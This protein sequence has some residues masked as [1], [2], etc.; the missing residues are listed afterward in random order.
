MRIVSVG[1]G[2]A[3]LYFAI[4]MKKADPANNITVYEQNRPGDTFG[5][6]VVFSDATLDKLATADAETYD[7][8]TRH[9]AHWD[10]IEIHYCGQVLTSTGHGFSGLARSTLLRILYHRC[11]ELG[12]EIQFETVSVD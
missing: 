7:E 9:F 10:D 8:I 3:G 5:F 11:E 6:G 2:P 12:I 1:G 4:L